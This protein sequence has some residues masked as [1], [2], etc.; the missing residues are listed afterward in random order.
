MSWVKIDK[1]ML[2]NRMTTFER[3]TISTVDNPTDENGNAVDVFQQAIDFAVAEMRN[4]IA[5]CPRNVLD[6]TAGTIP[7]SLVATLITIVVFRVASRG[8]KDSV[9]VQDSRYQMYSRA[10]E[11]LAE[12][13]ACKILAENPETGE[14]S[15]GSF[16]I[17]VASSRD[18]RFTRSKFRL[19]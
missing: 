14:L 11:T 2:L 4:A 13:R 6:S 10:M 7:E 3:D 9:M 16:G 12:L 1:T 19:M 8:L 15:T 18:D 17:S 5:T